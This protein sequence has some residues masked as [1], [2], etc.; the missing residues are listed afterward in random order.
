MARRS[1]IDT[2]SVFLTRL[3]QVKGWVN[4]WMSTRRAGTRSVDGY[5]YSMSVDLTDEVVT[6]RGRGGVTDAAG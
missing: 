5:D 4:P 6:E 2:L 1:S 3:E